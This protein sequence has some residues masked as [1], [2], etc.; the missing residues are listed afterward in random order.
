MAGNK[1]RTD[2]IEQQPGQLSNSRTLSAFHTHVHI[3]V[4]TVGPPKHHFVARLLCLR[5]LKR[6][7]QR[8]SA[9]RPDFLTETWVFQVEN[10]TL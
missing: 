10:R 1:R 3:T 8:S 2:H 4:S 7:L 5:L 6:N 9:L